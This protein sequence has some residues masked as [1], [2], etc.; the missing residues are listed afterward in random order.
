MEG[1]LLFGGKFMYSEINKLLELSKRGDIKAKEEL[2]LRLK[3]LILTS[4]KRNYNK[5]EEYD[6]L[7]QEGYEIVLEGIEEYDEKKGAHFL[8]YIGLRLKYHYLNKHRKVEYYCSLN[9][10][11]GDGDLEILDTI[12][13][14]E[15]DPLEYLLEGEEWKRL[16]RK[17]NILTKRQRQIIIEF[18]INQLT[19]EEIAEKLGISY[20]TVANTKHIAI[21]KLKKQW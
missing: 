17:L 2:V 21:N 20:R 18:Y 5:M 11:I 1:S 3:P 4:I 6:D 9:E 15:L 16:N 14:N 13:G 12:E 8:G 19:L 10:P 7:I